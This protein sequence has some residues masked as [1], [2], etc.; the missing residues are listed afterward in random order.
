MSTTDTARRPWIEMRGIYGWSPPEIEEARPL[1]EAGLNAIFMSAETVTPQVTDGLH[2]LGIRVFAE[3][4]S[5]H[6]A[7]WVKDHPDAAPVGPDGE[8]CPAPSGWQGVCPTHAE[9][10]AWRM[11]RFRQAL[12]AQPLDGI[13]LDYHHSHAAWEQAEPELPDTC[14]CD[15]CVAQFTRDTGIGPA[16]GSHAKPA[17]RL[18]GE[19]HE[20]WVKWRCDLFTDW[21]REYRAVLDATRPGALFG[22]FHC[23]WS[24]EDRDG[25]RISKLAIDLKAQAKHLDVFSIMPYH[26]RFGHHTDPG[27]ISRQTS[28]LGRYLGIEGKPG[29][30]HRIWPICQLSD[31][32]EA[33]PVE[34]V[35]EMLDHATRRPATGAMVFAWDGFRKQP[36][37]PE[38]LLSFYSAIR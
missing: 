11:E 16:A 14:F 31:W 26:A 32:G 15:R 33:V 1:A 24:D 34:Q 25:A 4:N 35:P 3:F 36:G 37:K 28:W 8:V 27:W 38:A 23:P 5:M 30:R 19:Y 10:R 2:G 7:R 9:Y 17:A 13:W 29:E 6:E 20:Q 22:S 18:L 12:A 21:V